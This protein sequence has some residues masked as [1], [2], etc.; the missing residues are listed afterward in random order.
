MVCQKAVNN[1][2]N[3]NLAC[4]DSSSQACWVAVHIVIRRLWK[5][6]GQCY[7]LVSSLFQINV[8]KFGAE[9]RYLGYWRIGDLIE[10]YDFPC[11]TRK[12]SRHS[13][14]GHSF[15]SRYKVVCQRFKQTFAFCYTSCYTFCYASRVTSFALIISHLGSVCV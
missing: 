6:A 9:H 7:S 5:K 15:P 4:F 13:H 2:Q 8:T 14:V 3:R 12:T 11:K 1:N 10:I